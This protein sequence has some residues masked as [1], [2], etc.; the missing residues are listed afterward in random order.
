M[1]RNLLL[2]SNSTNP[3]EAYLQWALGY[4]KDYFSGHGIKNIL[5]IPYAG[6]TVP[7]NDYEKKVQEVFSTLGFNIYSIHHS[8]NALAEVEKAEAL[9]VGGGNTFNLL[10]LVQDHNLIDA[11][12]QKVASGM[13]YCGWSAG[14]NLACPSLRTTNDMPIVQPQH[15][16][17]FNLIPFQINPHYLDANPAGHGGETR[18]QRI[19]EFL[20]ANQNITVAGLREASLLHV[21]G[22][23]MILK[24]RRNMRIFRYAQ[25]PVEIDANSDVSFLL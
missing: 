20:E 4:L 24:G 6:V 19:E 8:D 9:A 18:Q 7:W 23:S 25:E 10:K 1:Q 5:F 22:S 14:S 17:C 16:G 21:N 2:L 3:G 11:V 13:P 15:F 12:R